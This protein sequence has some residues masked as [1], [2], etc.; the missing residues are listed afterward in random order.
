MLYGLFS[1]GK[2]PSV[3]S[4]IQRFMKIDQILGQLPFI[5][6]NDLN[7]DVNGKYSSRHIL[8]SY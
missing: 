8:Q 2:T 7:S 6:F 5:K 3:S 1:P 4:K